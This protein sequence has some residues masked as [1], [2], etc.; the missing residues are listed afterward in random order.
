ML[1]HLGGKVA[2]DGMDLDVKV[3]QLESDCQHPM[4]L[5]ILSSTCANR[6]AM[7]QREQADTLSLQ[8]PTSGPMRWMACRNNDV[9]SWD[10]TA[11]LRLL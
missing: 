6:S 1:E 11:R 10:L 5:M 2:H 8:R 9:M 4:S 3:S 7:A